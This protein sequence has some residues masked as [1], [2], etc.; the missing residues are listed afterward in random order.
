MNERPPNIATSRTS[1]PSRRWRI[2]SA[3]S[4]SNGT[5]TSCRTHTE[6]QCWP[7]GIAGSNRQGEPLC[8][9]TFRTRAPLRNVRRW[10]CTLLPRYARA[11]G[12]QKESK[13]VPST[14][15]PVAAETVMVDVPPR[16]SREHVMVAPDVLKTRRSSSARRD[17]LHSTPADPMATMSVERTKSSKS[18]PSTVS[19]CPT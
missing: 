9:G 12:G 7:L 6:R 11:S 14:C 19:T 3:S 13:R 1:D 16:L 17:D 15:S 2:R 4:A 18:G 5:P 10:W 8:S